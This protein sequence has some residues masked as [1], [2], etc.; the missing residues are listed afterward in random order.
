MLSRTA[1]ELFWM[2]RY[3]ERAENLARV[4]DVTYKLSMMPRHHQQKHDLSLP[5]NLTGTHALFAEHCDTISINNL[6]TFF[7]LDQRNPSSIYSCIDM[8]WNNAHAVRSSLSSEV[9]EYINATR[10]ELNK[11]R[12]NPQ[13]ISMDN[14]FE[15]VKE[16][17]HLFRGA[18][19]G[20]LLKNDALRFIQLGTF[21]ERALATAQLLSVKD[22]QLNS[23]PDPVRQYYRLNTL[24]SAVSARETYHMIYRQP[25]SR[26]TVIELLVFRNDLP[27]SL[28][29]CVEKIVEKLEQLRTD[30]TMTPLRLAHQLLV[31]LRFSNMDDLLQE[32][33]QQYLS[34]FQKKMNH[35]ADNIRLTYLEAL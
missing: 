1:S 20:T 12:H 21:I 29:S 23:D 31:E 13:K 24:L 10:I 27:R 8:A 30:H 26:E 16:R 35:L 17:S 25:V 6:L 5:L 2:A 19:A 4:L 3:L 18:M 33:L 32:D 15:W 28:L 7:S 34:Q 11:F 9:W 22:S 14:L